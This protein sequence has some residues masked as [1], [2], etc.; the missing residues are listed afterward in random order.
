MGN[1]S[2]RVKGDWAWDSGAEEDPSGGAYH[3]LL[4]PVLAE[5]LEGRWLRTRWAAGG[6]ASGGPLDWE[7]ERA[8][9]LD[10][11]R[12]VSSQICVLGPPFPHLGNGL[13]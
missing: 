11:V 6:R 13:L 8:G 5:P 12:S 2:H 9:K 4:G 7:A 1:G 3:F 10:A